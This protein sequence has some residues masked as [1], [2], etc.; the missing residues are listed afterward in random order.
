MNI[1]ND[2][3]GVL[4]VLKNWQEAT[5]LKDRLESTLAEEIA[6][7]SARFSPEVAALD[8]Q[9]REAEA[10]LEAYALGHPEL[11]LAGGQP[12]TRKVGFYQ[13]GW[14]DNPPKVQ[15]PEGAETENS[16]IE[17]LRNLWLDCPQETRERWAFLRGWFRERETLARDVI[18]THATLPEVAPEVVQALQA[19]GIAVVRERRFVV[20][21]KP[22]LPKKVRA[23]KAKAEA[24][25]TPAADGGTE[26]TEGTEA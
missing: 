23:G 1:P 21:L 25:A 18:R 2:D 7:V 10:A 17:I 16:V 9:I 15:V 13:L 11:F 26:T 14:R 19:A 3:D 22:P 4:A 8:G 20:A 6:A 12:Q 24:A 5:A